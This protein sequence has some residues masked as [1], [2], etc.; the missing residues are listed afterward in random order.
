[1]RE[2]FDFPLK[3]LSLTLRL[4]RQIALTLWHCPFGA[5]AD[6]FEQ[7]LNQAPE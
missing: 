5:G 2:V 3:W 6:F 7:P 4:R 1:V